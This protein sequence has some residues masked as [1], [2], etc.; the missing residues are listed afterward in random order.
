MWHEGLFDR[1]NTARD[2]GM[3]MSYFRRQDLPFYYALADSFTIGDQYHQSTFTQTNP[4]RLHL[5]SGS[6][7]LSVGEEPVLDNTEPAYGFNWTTMGEVLEA[8]NITWRLYQTL[9]NFDDNGFAVCHGRHVICYHLVDLLFAVVSQL[10][11]G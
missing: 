1:W 9:D 4:N 5:F 2:P 7:G 8:A 6:N 10:Q 11:D 3:G